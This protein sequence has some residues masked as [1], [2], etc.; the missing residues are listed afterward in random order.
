MGWVKI[1]EETGRSYMQIGTYADR[2][3]TLRGMYAQQRAKHGSARE[4]LG[5]MLT[6]IQH[7][8]VADCAASSMGRDDPDAEM[9][10]DALATSI[11]SGSQVNAHVLQLLGQCAD[12]YVNVLDGVGLPPKFSDWGGEN[13]AVPDGQG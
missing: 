9:V 5:C 1:D 2:M 4:A 13:Q 10:G 3:A 12:L 6:G 7:M 11:L 8:Y